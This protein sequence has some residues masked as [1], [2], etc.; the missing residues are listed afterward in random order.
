MPIEE[1]P[2]SNRGAPEG[3]GS[4]LRPSLSLSNNTALLLL[5]LSAA[6]ILAAGAALAGL[7]TSRPPGDDSAEAGFARDMMV[8]HAQAVQMAEIVRDR[9]NS[10][11]MRLL[12]S[13]IALTQQAQIGIMQGWLQ[14]WGLP[15]TATEPA[16]AWM[17]H[18]MDGPM[19][20]M[21]TPE[22]IDRLS[23]VPPDVADVLFLRLMI[24]HHQ[25]AIP[26]AEALLKRS[27]RPEVR[28][29]AQSVEVSQRAEI[30]TMKA[31]LEERV[32]ASAHVEL[33][34]ANGSDTRGTVTLSK[35]DGGV[36]VALRV[37]GLPNSETM[38]LAHIHPGTCGEEEGGGSHEHGAHEHGGS[39]EIEYPLSQVKSDSEGRG[40]STT[41]LH[42]TSVEKLL[43]GGA[44][45][46]NVHAAGTGNPPILTCADLKE[47]R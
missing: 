24:R 46:V 15:M 45:Y 26:M 42:D 38:Y 40:S 27:D 25:A 37:S 36:K 5:L 34:P 14:A 17:G 29:L 35:R 32:G 44:R 28:A 3:S 43:S 30:E 16:M 23:E 8:H 19:P 4:K 11:T 9:T 10:D 22:E 13:D 47:A 31:M 6:A 41:T 2:P 20:G 1:P 12:A 7:L 33:E 39:E 21:A 18:P